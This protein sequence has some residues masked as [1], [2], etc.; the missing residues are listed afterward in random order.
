MCDVT[1]KK[2]F[3]QDPLRIR[4]SL[5]QDDSSSTTSSARVPGR[6]MRAVQTAET[7]RETVVRRPVP[8]DIFRLRAV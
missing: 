1:M 4:T 6:T 8:A 7:P 3:R 2:K 5:A